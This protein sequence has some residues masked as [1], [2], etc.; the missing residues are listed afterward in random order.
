MAVELV[1][2]WNKKTGVKGRLPKDALKHYPDYAT[3][4][5]QKARDAAAATPD[6]KES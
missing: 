2:V 4:P 1:D 3:T 5:R 6:T